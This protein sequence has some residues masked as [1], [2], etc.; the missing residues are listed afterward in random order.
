MS[1]LFPRKIVSS[2]NTTIPFSFIKNFRLS[3]AAFSYILSEIEA[4]IKTSK[5]CTSVPNVIKLCTALRF[6]AHGSYQLSV[7]NEFSIGLAQSTVSIILKDVVNVLEECICPKWIKYTYT[8]AEKRRAKTYFF[9]R[10]GIP[11]II[12]CVLHQST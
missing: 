2:L 9:E 12:G 10:S 8:D 7:G 4:K 5:R 11:G 6:F 1:I 3:K